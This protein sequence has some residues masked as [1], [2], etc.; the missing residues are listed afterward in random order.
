MNKRISIVLTVYD[1]AEELRQNLPLF[2]SQDYADGFEVIVVDESSTDDTDDVLTLLKSQHPHLYSTFLP[3][4][5]RNVVRRKLALTLGVKAAKNDWVIFADIN[6]PPSSPAWLQELSEFATA[7]NEL[8]LSYIRRKDQQQVIQTFP[9]LD[10]ARKLLS[11]N[12]RKRKK[13]FR[14]HRLCYLR[15]N[16]DFVLVQTRKAH[17][18]LTYFEQGIRGWHLFSM[19]TAVFFSQL[20][21]RP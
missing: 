20:A 7:D 12:E 18:T 11:K 9:L 5:N 17:E 15:G 2:L 1:Q 14:C 3:K 6:T 13:L 8:V 19:R 4:P 16:Y 10:D 21:D